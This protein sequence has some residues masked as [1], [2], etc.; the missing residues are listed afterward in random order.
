MP[1]ILHSQDDIQIITFSDPLNPQ[2]FSTLRLKIDQKIIQG[3]VNFIF[4]L[5]DIDF[6]VTRSLSAIIEL[7]DFC[8]MRQTTPS[9]ISTDKKSWKKIE[10]R[11]GNKIQ[12]F[13]NIQENLENL[14]QVIAIKDRDKE[15]KEPKDPRRSDLE[16]LIAEYKKKVP[17][18]SYDPLGLEMKAKQY[19][20]APS[21]EIL[22]ALEAAILQYK[23]LKAENEDTNQEV[24]RLAEQMMNLTSLRKKAI[25]TE[26]I[27]KRKK[28]LMI[29]LRIAEI[30]K[31]I[32]RINNG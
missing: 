20:T 11:T 14:K 30:E 9:V 25:R 28:E 22:K 15:Q 1:A 8:F 5:S 6:K 12:Y 4:D 26:E 19:K 18:R 31:E 23:K 7:V 3:R 17:I 32:L 2:D 27:A 13:A 21:K 24:T 10:S 16:K 29:L